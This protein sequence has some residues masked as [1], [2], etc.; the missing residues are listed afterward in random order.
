VVEPH[1]VGR[2]PAEHHLQFREAEEER[3]VAVEQRH[4]DGVLVALGKSRGQLEAAEAGAKDEDVLLHQPTVSDR[5][6]PV[7][8]LSVRSTRAS[9]CMFGRPVSHEHARTEIWRAFFGTEGVTPVRTRLTSRIQRAD[10]TSEG[11]SG[12]AR[13]ARA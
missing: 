2:L 8:S 9:G 7:E 13:S 4:A 1:S 11:T 5:G 12:N 10:A 6:E 3:V